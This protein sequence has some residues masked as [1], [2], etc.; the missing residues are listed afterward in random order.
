VDSEVLVTSTFRI[1]QFVKPNHSLRTSWFEAYADLHG[2]FYPLLSETGDGT[3]THIS[4]DVEGIV[5]RLLEGSRV[6]VAFPQGLVLSEAAWLTDSSPQLP[7][8]PFHGWCNPDVGVVG[9]THE[10]DTTQAADNSGAGPL[11]PLPGGTGGNPQ[12]GSRIPL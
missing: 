7:M 12:D 8:Q 6:V 11:D 4:W 9:L 2:G 5:M 1:G 3:T 10:E